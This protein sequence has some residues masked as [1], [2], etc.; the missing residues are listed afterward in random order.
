MLKRQR[1]QQFCGV[2]GCGK[3]FD[4][5]AKLIDHQRAHTGDKPFVCPTCKKAFAHV[6]HLRVHEFSHLKNE[7]RP[8]I[9]SV[10]G[11][12]H[13]SKQHHARHMKKHGPTTRYKCGYCSHEFVQKRSFDTHIARHKSC[14]VCGKI[15][16]NEKQLISHTTKWH[17]KRFH[18]NECTKR[19]DTSALL[20]QHIHQLHPSIKELPSSVAF[21]VGMDYE[22]RPIECPWACGQR[23]S[24][25]YDLRRHTLKEHPDDALPKS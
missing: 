1:P 11:K 25:H 24:R 19:F 18:C 21:L 4:R 9:C 22:N 5:P 2:P 8:H 23:F 17:S 16:A 12:G 7:K 6:K 15:L 3:S 20:R 14:S 13:I 10:C